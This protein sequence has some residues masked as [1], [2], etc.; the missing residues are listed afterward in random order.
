[1]VKGVSFAFQN[2][3]GDVMKILYRSNGIRLSLF[4]VKRR[5]RLTRASE[6]R[7]SVV[8]MRP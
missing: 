4:L 8:A 3:G 6:Q 1:M 5:K 2:T 7:A